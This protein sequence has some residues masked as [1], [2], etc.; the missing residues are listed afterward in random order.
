VAKS[1]APTRSM[2]KAMI[3]AGEVFIGD[4]VSDKPGRL[5]PP[6]I[7][8]RLKPRRR[9][10]SR[11]GDKLA[12][13]LQTFSVDVAGVSALDVGASTGGF[14]HCLLLAGAARVIALDVGRGQ[15][16]GALRN[17]PRVRPIERVNARSLGCDQ[18][19]Y[20]PDFLTMDISF[21]SIVKVLPAVVACMTPAFR[22]L[23]LIKPQFEAGIRQVG[24]GGIVRDP[25]V[26]RDVL[27]ER[28]RFV[29]EELGV[30][31]WGVCSSGVLGTDGNREFF[32]YLGRDGDKG[33]GL[34]TLDAAVDRAIV[35]ITPT[36]EGLP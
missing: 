30:E 13:A 19:P 20:R 12:N 21:I 4:Q 11:G 31:L 33:L 14:V 28:S 29:I 27:R 32:L 15:L 24:K 5:L 8:I 16:D 1:L 3:M 18:L 23:V 10:V 35:D 9:F 26:H 2:A 17:D 25:N 34:D 36:S 7:E 22:G 6:E